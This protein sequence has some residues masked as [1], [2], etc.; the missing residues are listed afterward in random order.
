MA[1]LNIL[2]LLSRV[3]AHQS[4]AYRAEIVSIR[5]LHQ[6]P[7]SLSSKK[8]THDKDEINPESN[9]YS[10]SGSDHE[11]AQMDDPSFNPK[12]TSPEKQKSKAGDVSEGANP[13]EVS[14]ANPDVSKGAGSKEAQNSPKEQS[15]SS[16]Q[17][18]HGSPKKGKKV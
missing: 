4:P 17:S 14:P 12:R 18:G 10:K 9:E 15:S 13:L 6:G 11:A 5:H 1:G 16:K 7:I 8:G 2:R 3:S